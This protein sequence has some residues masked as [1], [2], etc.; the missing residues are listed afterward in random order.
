MLTAAQLEERKTGIG[1]SEIAIIAG[2]NK[3][4]SPYELY[5]EKR[6]DLAPRDLSDNVAVM[7]GDLFE[8]GIAQG[9]CRVRGKREGREVKVERRNNTQ[10][11]KD[12]PWALAHVDRK[13]V[14]EPRGLECK[15]VGAFADREAWGPDGSD[16]VPDH[17]LLQCQWYMAVVGYDEWDLASA[18]GNNDFRIHTIKR[19]D[20]LI[21]DLILLGEDFWECVQKGEAPDVDW[22]SERTTDIFKRLYPGTDG[23]AVKAKGDLLTW[24]ATL[25]AAKEQMDI[26]KDVVTGARNHL[27]KSMGN[28]SY[29]LMPDGGGYTRKTVTRAAYSVEAA[30]YVDFRYS[31]A[32]KGIQK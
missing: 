22:S 17:M 11:R 19:D 26:Y 6:G 18:N 8:D 25:D 27:L 2:L 1:G 13:V 24:H 3:R 15:L 7:L 29:L 28:A 12:L 31:K 32:I 4:S 16:Q 14:G 21:A 10:R 20:A 23:S 5:L 9:Y 30:S